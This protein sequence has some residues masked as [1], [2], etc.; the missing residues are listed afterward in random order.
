VLEASQ[1]SLQGGQTLVE[2]IEPGQHLLV[3]LAGVLD[4]LGRH[5]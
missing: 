5:R 1:Q 4:D 3:D 2:Q